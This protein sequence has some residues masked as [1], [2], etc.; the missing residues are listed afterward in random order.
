MICKSCGGESR[1]TTCAHCG[2][3]LVS[4]ALAPASPPVP[5]LVKTEAKPARPPK[6]A[7]GTSREVRK[8]AFYMFR[9]KITLGSVLPAVLALLLPLAYLFL[10]LFVAYPS[11]V[12]EGEPAQF[13]LLMLRLADGALA[14]NPVSDI[15]AATY[16]DAS[17]AV[18]FF[19]IRKA[20][21]DAALLW[22]AAAI[23]IAVL[24]CAVS[25]VLLLFTFG[26]ILRSRLLTDFIVCSAFLGAAAPFAATLLSY[27]NGPEAFSAARVH[28]TLEAV[29]LAAILLCLLPLAARRI[30]RVAWSRTT[31]APLGARLTGK[32]CGIGGV[33]LIGLL[34]AGAAVALPLLPLFISF[35]DSG[36]LLPR[37][38]EEIAAV[39]ADFTA[40][41]EGL[42]AADPFAAIAALSRLGVLLYIPLLALLSLLAFIAFFR[43]LTVSARRTARK[44]RVR[45]RLARVGTAL[46]RPL[47]LM[48]F[49]F[50]AFKVVTVLVFFFFSGVKLRIVGTAATDMLGLFY[51]LFLFAKSLFSVSCMG[52]LLAL[53]TFVCSL[54]SGGLAR[55]FVR[56]AEAANAQ[57]S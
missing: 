31:Y 19:G 57:R 30:Y 53:G 11:A 7:R 34:F 18:S 28:F 13:A 16:G 1:G 12:F 33:R 39:G 48:L 2:A 20:L 46:R 9:A 49:C 47:W 38:I 26:R 37:F 21:E 25:A 22:P 24:L 41:R 42:A 17:S 54:V 5:A 51:L 3:P 27:L 55:A 52:A 56:L 50:L 32:I 44:P 10:D 35:G 40:L 8:A 14:Q 29:L 15:M 45:A 6:T 4:E 43:M 23:L 36:A